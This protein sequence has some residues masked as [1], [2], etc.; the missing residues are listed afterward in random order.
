MRENQANA[1][2]K[3]QQE[4]EDMFYK[5]LPYGQ[6]QQGA[7]P[8]GIGANE[9]GVFGMG[10]QEAPRF[11][12]GKSV[13]FGD[14]FGGEGSVLNFRNPSSDNAPTV[15]GTALSGAPNYLDDKYR[16]DNWIAADRDGGV[17]NPLI[18]A[19][20]HQAFIEP[21]RQQAR[22]DMLKEKFRIAYDPNSTPEQK[23]QALAL[24]SG[25]L[26][27]DLIGDQQW[28][29]M[30]R[31]Q[32]MKQW[33]WADEER[34]YKMQ[35]LKL[36]NA[37]KDFRLR[38]AMGLGIENPESYMGEDGFININTGTS[39][40]KKNGTSSY[41]RDALVSASSAL[42]KSGIAF[43]DAAKAARGDMVD[44]NT[45]KAYKTAE[46]D[47]RTKQNAYVEQLTPYINSRQ[48]GGDFDGLANLY[49]F[50]N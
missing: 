21:L 44:E 29:D 7:I 49:R 25:E 34:P 24:L 40:K 38:A 30:Q 5:N 9:N 3:R 31:N 20:R 22:Q 37:L 41:N 26:G 6:D 27:K 33:R 13:G 36:G 16:I 45:K 12:E 19:I 23:Q 50:M 18:S 2:R 28:R 43:K 8:Q 32:Q 11:T 4:R 10:Q 35:G 39:S 15:A 17:T 42:A 47:F 14:L 48:F 1:D 46:T